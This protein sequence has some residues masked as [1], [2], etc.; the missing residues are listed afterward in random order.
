[1]NEQSLFRLAMVLQNQAPSTLN[2]Y[3]CKLAVAI[4]SENPDGLSKNELAQKIDEQFNLNFVEN[5]IDRALSKKGGSQ[6]FFDKGRYFATERAILSYKAGMSY[7]D[8]LKKTINRFI[9]L[10][11]F[12]IEE[13]KL[14]NLLMKYLYFC[15]NSNVNNL[16]SLINTHEISDSES[17]FEATND[18]IVAINA[19]IEWDDNE[20]NS[21]VY[22]IVAICYE[23]CMLTIK[24]DN[25]LSKELFKGKR[26]YLD[27]NIIFRMAGINNEERQF[28]TKSFERHCK[29]AGIEL[30]CTE[31]TYEELFRV[32]NSQ[33]SYIRSFSGNI[34]P[35][36]CDTLVKL[37]PTLEINDFYKR[38]YEWC[39]IPTNSFGDYT[40]FS[41][42]LFD[43][44]QKTIVNLK[45]VPSSVYKASQRE[46][47]FDSQVENLIA[48]KNSK[49][50]RQTTKASAETDV[51]NIRDILKVRKGNGT[52]L[53][54]TN[55]FMVSA[56]HRLIDWADDI[57]PGVPIVVLPSVWLSIILRYTGRTKDD[58]KSFCLFL[59]Q[60]Q[61]RD[62]SE[63]I[64]S[65][66]LLRDINFRTNDV[67]VRK[68]IITEIT[69]HRGDYKFVTEEDY[70]DNVDKAFDKI[71]E[72]YD[73]EA[74]KRIEL[75]RTE[76]LEQKET[77][78][79]EQR[80]I[81]E[82]TRERLLEGEREKTIMILAHEKAHN[83]VVFFKFIRKNEW[84]IYIGGGIV[85]LLCVLT[86]AFEWNP[87]YAWTLSILPEKVKASAEVFGIVWTIVSL[88]VGG[89]FV[90]IGKIIANL[91][92]DD[93]ESKLI[94]K[95]YQ[96][97]IVKV[98]GEE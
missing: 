1:M 97:Y 82:E 23:Y 93:F 60:R 17:A 16:L 51:T 27:A 96:R 55:D 7:F 69:E 45:I 14:F 73:S 95:Y 77:E 66:M 62:Q 65:A 67:E 89:I 98:S 41:S 42:Y 63:I 47:Q 8:I 3:I 71:L 78:V 64:D 90:G 34:Q 30:I 24:K 79:N 31:S 53:W 52:N 40:G 38:Y 58:Y 44:V 18:E 80:R 49:R 61:H 81:D 48:Y 35:I 56:D 26:F 43:L 32:I 54:Q 72:Q 92:S 11:S 57:F 87:L 70:S 88:A 6:I 19:F 46:N 76:L 25:F 28:V 21:L 75:L 74:A 2:K 12:E 84:I 13:D 83:K 68:R 29:D 36:D 5:E 91:G 37:N 20:K 59:T 86:W 15:F 94:N 85:L 39:Q 22:H 10:T 33:V 50:R 4:L 9:V